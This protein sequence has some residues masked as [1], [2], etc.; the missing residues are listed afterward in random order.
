MAGAA[1]V[2]AYEARSRGWC[3]MKRW[4]CH[5]ELKGL[6]D[7]SL[8]LLRVALYDARFPALFEPP[9]YGAIIGMFELNNLGATQGTDVPPIASVAEQQNLRCTRDADC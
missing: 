1:H 6:A 9:V 7:D 2:A 3:D 8:Q 4:R 5:A